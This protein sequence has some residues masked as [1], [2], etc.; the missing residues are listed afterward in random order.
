MLRKLEDKKLLYCILAGCILIE[1]VLEFLLHREYVFM[2]DDMWYATNLVTGEPLK[3]FGDI[4]EGQ[5]WHYL[6]WGGRSVNHTV[7][8]LVL[9]CGD[10][11]C[12]IANI[13]VTFTLSYLICSVAGKK[14]FKC[15][16]FSFFLLISLN[17]DIKQ[18]MFWQSGSVN[19]LYST[20]WILLFL[21][22]Y[23]RQVKE[24][25]NKKL[26]AVDFWIV[27]LGLMT[28]WS[29]ENMG[30]ACFVTAIIVMVYFLKG[31][32]RKPPVW[33]WIGAVSSFVGSVLLILAPGN[34]ARS[35]TVV[36]KSFITVLGERFY[37]LL[38]AGTSYLFPTLLLMLLLVFVYLQVGNRLQPFQMILMGTF[39]L[40][41]GAMILSP[42]FPN[43]AAFGL[44]VI[45]IV[46]SVSFAQG[47]EEKE[48]SYKKYISL[49]S[50]YM[51]I[52]GV[53]SLV[54]ALKLPIW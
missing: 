28:G 39:V 53:Y 48:E 14:D 1:I 51:W 7:L 50:L 31:L 17:T 13:I 10:A 38:M 27:P 52:Y 25:E 16:C 22:A 42:T 19:Y 40:A 3:N 46:L 5:V 18:S 44:M 32:K 47:I 41:F 26:R 45:G 8:Q 24:P 36:E 2:R 30:P 43:R 23:I 9:M 4:L 54:T 11:F 33:M 21:L 29:N 34:F 12:N 15:F 37:E 49:L 35:A 20:N 6:N